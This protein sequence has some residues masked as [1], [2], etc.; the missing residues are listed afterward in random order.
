MSPRISGSRVRLTK[1]ELQ[2]L[3]L[4]YVTLILELRPLSANSLI[5]VEPKIGA[6]MTTRQLAKKLS[7]WHHVDHIPIGIKEK[8]TKNSPHLYGIKD[9]MIVNRPGA[10]RLSIDTSE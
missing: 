2:V 10:N 3:E 8:R 7:Y 4:V 9:W 1:T 5:A 6:L